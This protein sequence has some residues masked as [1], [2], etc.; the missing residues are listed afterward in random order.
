ML[1]L[2]TYIFNTMRAKYIQS[3]IRLNVIRVVNATSQGGAPD[4][5]VNL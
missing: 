5:G 1:V 3:I 4:G 2:D